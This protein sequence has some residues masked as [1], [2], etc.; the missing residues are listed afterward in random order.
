MFNDKTDTVFA[1]SK[2]SLKEWYFMIYVFLRFN[3]SIR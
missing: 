3:T 2:L 1:H